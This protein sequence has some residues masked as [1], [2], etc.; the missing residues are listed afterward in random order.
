MGKPKSIF[1]ETIFCPHC[2]EGIKVKIEKETI[3]PATPAETR[4][5]I[6]VEKSVQ[7]TLE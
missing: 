6:S 4:I 7:T 1:D 3:T 5:N 2:R